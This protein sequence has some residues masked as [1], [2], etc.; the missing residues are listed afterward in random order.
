MNGSGVRQ[1]RKLARDG[2]EDTNSV[3]DLA[4]FLRNTAPP[5]PQPSLPPTPVK[6][7]GG[8]SRMFSRRKKSAT[9]S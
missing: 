7:E 4:E 8:F 1:A 2:R 6:E 5:P 9:V 3:R